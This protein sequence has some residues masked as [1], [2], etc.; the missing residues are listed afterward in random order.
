MFLQ[1]QG[2]HYSQSALV[3]HIRL[4]GSLRTAGR[5]A[6]EARHPPRASISSLQKEILRSP[7]VSD[8]ISSLCRVVETRS[9]KERPY[10]CHLS[11]LNPF[12]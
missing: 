1:A 3:E 11:L 9:G 7:L 8:P 4:G 5:G 12:S 2:S 6:A 10:T